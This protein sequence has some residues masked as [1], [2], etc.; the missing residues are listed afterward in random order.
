MLGTVAQI[1]LLLGCVTG[2]PFM[3]QEFCCKASALWVVGGILI[4][5]FESL[6]G[7]MIYPTIC[8]LVRK[9]KN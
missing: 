7:L 2:V 8:L 9:C 4:V 5:P 1:V 3:V 6:I